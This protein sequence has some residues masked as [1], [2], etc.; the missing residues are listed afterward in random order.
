M[1]YVVENTVKMV[2]GGYTIV[3]EEPRPRGPHQLSRPLRPQPGRCPQSEARAPTY[4]LSTVPF[5]KPAQRPALEAATH[6]RHTRALKLRSQRRPS[7]IHQ[8]PQ[9]ERKRGQKKKKTN[10][11]EGRF[12]GPPDRERVPAERRPARAPFGPSAKGSNENGPICKKN[13]SDLMRRLKREG[14][15]ENGTKCEKSKCEWDVSRYTRLRDVGQGCRR[16]NRRL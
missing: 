6:E 9:G 12:P 11:L 4:Q 14:P 7:R 2:L 13:E 16:S 5:G 8:P 15:N 3:R 1:S 10:T